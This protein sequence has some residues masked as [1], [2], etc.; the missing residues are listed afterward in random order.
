MAD[1]WPSRPVDVTSG[2]SKAGNCGILDGHFK[3]DH[4]S[5]CAEPGDEVVGVLSVFGQSLFHEVGRLARVKLEVGSSLDRVF[6]L[7]DSGP[8]ELKKLLLQTVGHQ[9]PDVA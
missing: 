2:G 5:Y 3:S 4:R 6:L 8:A 1:Q 9:G 7:R